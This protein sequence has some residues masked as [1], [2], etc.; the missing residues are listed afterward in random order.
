MDSMINILFICITV[1]MLFLLLIIRHR[2]SR[3]IVGYMMIGLMICYGVSD[4]N[5]ILLSA[6]GYDYV[7]VTTALTPISEEILKALPV[8]FYAFHISD[9]REKL[10]AV[11]FAE[12]IGFAILENMVILLQNISGVSLWWALVRGFGSALMHGLC[13]GMVGLGMHYIHQKRKLFISGTFAML[14]TAIIYH[15][16]YNTLV[17]SDLRYFGFILPLITFSALMAYHFRDQLRF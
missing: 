17:Q 6:F 4:L 7:Y 12:G 10:E 8:L 16:I 15:S 2:T 1:P 9:N 3:T 5:G 11:A 14:I 13:T